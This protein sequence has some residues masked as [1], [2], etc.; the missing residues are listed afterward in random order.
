ME[1]ERAPGLLG[2]GSCTQNLIYS[3]QTHLRITSQTHRQTQWYTEINTKRKYTQTQTKKHKHTETRAAADPS[4]AWS[5]PNLPHTASMASSL[6]RMSCTLVPYPN[7][8]TPYKR[9]PKLLDG[10]ATGICNVVCVLA[11]IKASVTIASNIN[12]ILGMPGS[13][14]KMRTICFFLLRNFSLWI[15]LSSYHASTPLPGPIILPKQQSARPRTTNPVC[16]IVF[17]DLA[18]IFYL[19]KQGER[20]GGR[21]TVKYF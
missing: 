16:I 3:I 14:T 11:I 15:C 4:R 7:S 9:T 18:T 2:A 1:K 8:H 21:E 17:Q 6:S 5:T 20:R 19:S 12:P 10:T 13:R